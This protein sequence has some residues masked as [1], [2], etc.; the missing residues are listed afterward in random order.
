[1]NSS[2]KRWEELAIN[3][4]PPPQSNC[5]SMG[6]FHD[7]W[8]TVESS[9]QRLLVRRSANNIEMA[10]V[11]KIKTLLTSLLLKNGQT[12]SVMLQRMAP[13][14]L[15]MLLLGSSVEAFSFAGHP[16]VSAL[17]IPGTMRAGKRLTLTL[18]ISFHAFFLGLAKSDTQRWGGSCSRRWGFEQKLNFCGS[19]EN[20]LQLR[21]C[22]GE[23]NPIP[24]MNRASFLAGLAIAAQG[25]ILSAPAVADTAATPD[26]DSSSTSDEVSPANPHQS[27]GSFARS[28]LDPGL[29]SCRPLSSRASTR[30]SWAYVLP[31]LSSRTSSLEP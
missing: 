12:S 5:E 3:R 22:L 27:M 8:L 23:A 13:F 7:Y 9:H 28:F 31:P 20:R 24:K 21:A 15:S 29:Y 16:E 19:A 17:R 4:T 30:K 11:K 26:A 25:I 10:M 14:L 2:L 18:A 6:V 1:M